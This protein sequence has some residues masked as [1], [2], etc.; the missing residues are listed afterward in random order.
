M[1]DYLETLKQIRPIYNNID[2]EERILPYIDEAINLFIIPSIG[3]TAYRAISEGELKDVLDGG[4]FSINGK[5][6]YIAGLKKA[7][8]Y[9]TYSRLIKNQQISVTT[10][11]VDNLN[12]EYGEKISRDEILFQSNEAKEIGLQYLKDVKDYLGSIGLIDCC[13]HKKYPKIKVIE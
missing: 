10:Y 7:V 4:F 1:I 9:L 8:A 6:T 11:S 2:N 5:D 13:N 12:S 3:A